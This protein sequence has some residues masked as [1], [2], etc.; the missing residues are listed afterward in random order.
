MVSIAA[1]L[2]ARRACLTAA[3]AKGATLEAIAEQLGVPALALRRDFADL[4]PPASHRPRRR[5]RGGP[6]RADL[7]A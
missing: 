4:T 1:T 5:Q 7:V 3:L 2:A 6:P